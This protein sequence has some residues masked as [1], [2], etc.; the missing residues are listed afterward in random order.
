MSMPQLLEMW[1]LKKNP[2]KTKHLQTIVNIG[3]S[4][5]NLLGID[6][7]YNQTRNIKFLIETGPD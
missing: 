5:G 3:K 1:P 6:S 4:L 2:P 7:E